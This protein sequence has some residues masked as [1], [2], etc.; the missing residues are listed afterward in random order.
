MQPILNVALVGYGFV[1]K[2]FHAQSNTRAGNAR[3]ALVPLD[4]ACAA[5]RAAELA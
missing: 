4:T 5:R 2:V 1:G 3:L